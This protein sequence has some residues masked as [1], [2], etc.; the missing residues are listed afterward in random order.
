[1]AEDQQPAIHEQNTP[2]IP[3]HSQTQLTQV[4][5]PPILADISTAHSGIPIG[6]PPPTAQTASNLVESARFTTLERTVNQLAINMATNMTELMAMLRDQNR[7]SSSFTP[8]LER[9]PIVDPNPT[10]PLTFASEVEDASFSAMA[11]APTVHPISDPL[12][13][14]PAPT[15]IPLPPA[16]FLSA[17]STMHTLPPLTVSMRPPI[18]TVPPPTVPPVTIAQAPIPIADQFPFQTPQPQISLSYPAPPPLTNIPLLPLQPVTVTGSQT[19][20]DSLTGSALDWFMTLKADDVPTWTDLSHKFLDQYRFC[21]ETPPTLL[22]LS[23]ME[24]KEDQT[25]EAY[26]AEW[27]GKAAKHVPAITEKQQVQLFHSTLR[28]AYYSHLL[29]HTSSF[30]ELIE[31]GKKLDMGIKLG[32]IEGP[33]RKKEGKTSETTAGAS[34]TGGKKGKETSVNA[35]NLGHQSSQT[36]SVSFTPTPLPQQHIPVQAQPNKIPALRPQ[37][38]QQLPAPQTQQGNRARSKPWPQYPP[39]PVPQSQIYRQLLAAEKIFPEAPHPQFNAAN[40]N[41]TLRCEYHMDAPGHTT[42]NCYALRGKLQEMIDKNNLSLNK[43]R[44]PNVQAN[45]LPDHGS[46]SGPTVNM[47]GAYFL[48]ED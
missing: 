41:Q 47:I 19:F 39:L 37:P 28:G 35:V 30:S 42:D 13:P 11:Y 15:A 25:F 44:P 10:A 27:R 21:A 16:A 24:M 23:M 32:R 12:P 43:I 9:R 40:Q 20:Q 31:A 4:I 36:Y 7:A 3:T 26:A 33:T 6:H 34:S 48:G 5:S 45:P 2:P 1:M 29:S 8:P 18:Y 46:S 22:D 17:D 14:P 38:A